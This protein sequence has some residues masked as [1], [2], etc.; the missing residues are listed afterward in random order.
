MEGVE[1][2]KKEGRREVK[3]EKWEGEVVEKRY[4][5]EKIRS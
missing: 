2:K 4:C 5:R 1:S 3:R